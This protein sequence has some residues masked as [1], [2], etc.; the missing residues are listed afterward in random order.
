ML[1][2]N[3]TPSAAREVVTSAAST[4]TTAALVGALFDFTYALRRGTADPSATM[5]ILTR[6]MAAGPMR[7]CDLAHQLH[8]D[9]STVSRHVAALSAEGLVARTPQQD[10]RRAHFVEL[11]EAGTHAARTQVSTRVQQ[12]EAVIAAWPDADVETFARLLASF[13]TGLSAHERTTS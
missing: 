6:L 3:I 2:A 4:S 1:Q 8:L 7:S 9:Q 11:T 12:V 10:D 5:P 13:A